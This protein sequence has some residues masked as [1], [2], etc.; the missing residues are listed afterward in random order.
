MGDAPGNLNPKKGES[1]E[2]S[3][4][5]RLLIAFGLMMVILFATPYILRSPQTPVE[6]KKAIPKEAPQPVPPPAAVT[7]PPTP[8]A[9]AAVPAEAPA[10]LAAT[11]EQT[12]TVDTKLYEVTFSNRGAVVTSW[13]LK[14]YRGPEGPLELVNANAG[15]QVGYPM[16]VHPAPPAQLSVDLNQM[17]FAV[18]QSEDGRKLEF[19]YSDGK[20]RAHKT[21]SFNPASYVSTITS[22]IADGGN[23]VPHVLTWRGGFG[24]FPVDN[25]AGRMHSVYFDSAENELVLLEAKVGRDAPDFRTGRYQFAGIQD[26][27]FAA[28]AFTPEERMGLMTFSNEVPGPREGDK[29]AA[30]V[31]MGVGGEGRQQFSL[32]VGPK[33][34]NVLRQVDP[35]LEKLVDFGWFTF[36]AHPLFLGLKWLHD[37]YVHNY[38]WSIVLI[39]VLINMALLPL[40][41]TSM[42]SMKKM[43]ALQPQIAAIN[44]KYKGIGLRDPKKA[45]QNQ[46]VMDLYK[47]HGV[48]PAGGCLPILLQL[49]FFFAFYKV[50]T[51]AIELRGADWLWVRDLSAPEH[52]PIHILPL[53]MVASQFVMQKMTPATSPDPMQQ[54]MMLFMPLLF[55]FMFYNV[56]SGLVLYWITGNLVGIVQQWFI[57][58]TTPAPAVPQPAVVNVKGKKVNRK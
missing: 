50:L 57:N 40:K 51:V 34:M 47:K 5:A 7:A 17:L 24:D 55:G 20:V 41:L 22:E 49:P 14:E 33:E 29:A 48:N 1:K 28:V 19:R 2:L 8:G 3:M 6:Q 58:R 11:E 10:P 15:S 43:G 54:R 21:F 13:R 26:T 39:T 30:F 38:G 16:S 23:L 35:K 53:A 27:Y 4:E 56:S 32:F 31:G 46:E 18:E 9:R 37:N 12:F 44:E 36:L 52:L 45:Q 25:P 42:K